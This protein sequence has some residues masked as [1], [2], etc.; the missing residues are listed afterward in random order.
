MFSS[1]V[2]ISTTKI[3]YTN[4]VHKIYTVSFPIPKYILKRLALGV[5]VHLGG[6][7]L[8]SQVKLDEQQEG[9]SVSLRCSYQ[10]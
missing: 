3:F 7:A 2:N 10:R 1:D 8:Q 9:I 4:T 6:E 5:L